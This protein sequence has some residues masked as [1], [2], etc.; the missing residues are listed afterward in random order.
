MSKTLPGVKKH[1]SLECNKQMTGFD[2][3]PFFRGE[4]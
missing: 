3:I 2:F 4:T 1:E